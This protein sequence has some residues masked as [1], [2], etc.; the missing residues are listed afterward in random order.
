MSTPW[1]FSHVSSLVEPAGVDEL[2]LGTLWSLSE[3]LRFVRDN[4]DPA[5]L[6]VDLQAAPAASVTWATFLARE[7]QVALALGLATEAEQRT[8][9]TGGRPPA[10]FRAHWEKLGVRGHERRDGSPADDYLDA[11]FK[12]SRLTYVSSTE[13]RVHVNLGSRA[14]RVSDFLSVTAPA[15]DDVVFDLGSGSG[16]LALTVAASSVTAVQGVEL[17]AHAVADSNGSA[18]ALGLQNVAFHRAD[19][20][21]VDLSAG[22]IFYLYYPFHGAVASTVASTLG[23]LAD[24]KDITIYASGPNRDYGEFFLREVDRGALSLAERRGEFDEVMVLQSARR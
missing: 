19:V 13:E 9:R 20:R 12:T 16:K 4:V 10:A 14:S 22:S 3:R 18:R 8:I 1:W 17:L 21:D 23:Q 7:A 5:L 2:S 24:Q 6:A 11:L 15:E